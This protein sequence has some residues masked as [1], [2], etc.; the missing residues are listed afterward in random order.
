[1]IV[2]SIVGS[3]WPFG[4]QF[5][6]REEQTHILALGTRRLTGPGTVRIPE[7][8]LLAD[9]ELTLHSKWKSIDKSIR[10]LRLFFL[11]QPVLCSR[12]K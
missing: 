4:G 1:M 6:T 10:Y 9:A 8:D 2:D 3:G 12:S 11:N 5:L 7:A